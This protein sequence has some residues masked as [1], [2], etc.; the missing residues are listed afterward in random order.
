MNRHRLALLIG[1][2]A[3]TLGSGP[4][5]PILKQSGPLTERR[6]PTITP[7]QFVTLGTVAGG[8]ARYDLQIVA[9]VR[10][11]LTDSGVKAVTMPGRFDNE[12]DAVVR[13]CARD[14]TPLVDGVLFVWYNR[15]ELHDCVSQ[16][17]AYEI[18]GEGRGVNEMADRLVAYLKSRSAPGTQ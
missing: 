14:A 1:A 4:C 12:R 11:Q 8:G 6:H 15:L 9:T 7:T 3:A 2:A 13:G 17:V 18:S 16:A 10:Q 5:G